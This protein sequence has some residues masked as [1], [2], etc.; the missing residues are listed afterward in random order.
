MVRT[1][2]AALSLAAVAAAVLAVSAGGTGRRIVVPPGFRVETFARGLSQ[3]TAMAYGPD[4][5]IYVTQTGGTLVAI[6]RGTRA[7]RVLIR[8]LRTPLGLVWRGRD[9]FV[10]ERGRLERLTLRAG[11][12]TARRVIVQGLPF[13]RHQQD[14]LDLWKG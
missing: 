4:G 5:R 12:P 14:N 11:R 9:L 13:G 6:K 10:S 3:P 2:I 1:T 8:G 7:P